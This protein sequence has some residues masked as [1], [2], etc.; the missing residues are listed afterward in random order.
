[1]S[2]RGAAVNILPNSGMISK[3]GEIADMRWIGEFY[4]LDRSM[5]NTLISDL[6]PL[7]MD[8]HKGERT[9]SNASR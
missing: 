6:G 7:R 4:G 3:P 1:M 2:I 8:E 5:S 9:K